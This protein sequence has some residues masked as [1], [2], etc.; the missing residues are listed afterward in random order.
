MTKRWIQHP[1]TGK[2]IPAHLYRRP[3]KRSGLA[4]PSVIGD[5]MEPTQS[6]LDGRHYE[7]KSALRKTYREAGVTEVG[8]DAPAS[9][10]PKTK[11]DRKGVE[12]SVSRALSQA[13]FGA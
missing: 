8:S 3:A 12:A 1:E 5:T 4:A 10:P 2:L 7:S 11:P 6:M 9:P 13:G